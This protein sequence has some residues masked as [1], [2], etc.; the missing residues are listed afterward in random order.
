VIDAAGIIIA[1]VIAVVMAC[2][3]FAIGGVGL[4]YMAACAFFRKR[5]PQP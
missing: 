5:E 3:L 4:L 2:V 1:A